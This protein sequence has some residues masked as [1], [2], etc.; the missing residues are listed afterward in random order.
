MH[1]PADAA[2]SPRLPSAASSDYGLPFADIFKRADYDFYAID[3]ALFSPAWV[4][5]TALEQANFRDGGR[6]EAAR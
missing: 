6:D 5:V 1:R 4:A 3:P 2:A